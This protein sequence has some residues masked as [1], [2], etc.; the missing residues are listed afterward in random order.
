MA[1]GMHRDRQDEIRSAIAAYE[2]ANGNL[3]GLSTDSRRDCLC[4][5]VISSLRRIEWVRQIKQ[6]DISADR[7]D[8]HSSL[9]DPIRAAI[10]YTRNGEFEQAV[11][12]TFIQTHFGKHERDGWKLAANVYGSFREG[13]IWTYKHY[14]NDPAEFETMLQQNE[15]KLFNRNISGAFS[16]HRKYQSKRPHKIARTFRTFFEWQSEFGGLDQRVREIHKKSGQE[17]A[18]T[19]DMLYKSL[20]PVFGF[21]GGRLGRFDFLTM[22]GKLDLAPIVPGSVYLSGATGPYEGAKLLFNGETKA[23]LSR[24]E[25]QKKM[26]ELDDFLQVGK[27]V[28]EDS[29]CNWQKSPNKFVHFKG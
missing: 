14:G 7:S 8:P 2:K 19:F 12:M 11:W 26:N 15:A 24:V 16:N 1:E 20:K 10:L 4:R 13:P 6:S 3:P 23:P 17:P 18:S 27:Q 25:L 22:L 9:F 28:I 21:G 5:Q 29:V